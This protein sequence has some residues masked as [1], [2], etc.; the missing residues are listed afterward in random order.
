MVKSGHRSEKLSYVKK[1]KPIIKLDVVPE[2][3]ILVALS[4]D[5]NITVHDIDPAVVNFPIIIEI[6]YSTIKG[7]ANRNCEITSG[8]VINAAIMKKTTTR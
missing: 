6:S 4:S 3:S 8:G 7:T 5:G 2:F 1:T